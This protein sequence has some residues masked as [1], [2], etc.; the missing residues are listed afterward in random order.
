MED[1]LKDEQKGKQLIAQL[2]LGNKNWESKVSP[3][4]FLNNS[5]S[6]MR[7]DDHALLLAI[8]QEAQI[9]TL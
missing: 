4:V 1:A 6:N 5:T 9:E 3:F 8:V 2:R 7:T